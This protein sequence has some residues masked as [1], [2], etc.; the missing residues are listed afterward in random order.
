MPKKARITIIKEAHP[1]Y[2]QYFDRI[3]GNMENIELHLSD[4]LRREPDLENIIQ[5]RLMEARKLARESKRLIA[6]SMNIDEREAELVSLLKPDCIISEPNI[7]TSKYRQKVRVVANKI[8]IYDLRTSVYYF[9]EY[10]LYLHMRTRFP[11]SMFLKLK[12]IF[13]SVIDKS[14]SRRVSNIIE[15][16]N[17]GNLVVIAGAGHAEGTRYHLVKKGYDVDIKDA[18][19]P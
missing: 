6:E 19:R 10:I 12:P 9:F 13:V 2:I 3:V 7:E 4:W 5:S 16:Y 8:P 1:E 11:H 17:Y 14:F 15:T 18:E